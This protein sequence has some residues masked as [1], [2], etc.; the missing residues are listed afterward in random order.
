[1]MLT[2]KDLLALGMDGVVQLLNDLQLGGVGEV[3]QVWSALRL[4]SH[5]AIAAAMQAGFKGS[6]S[7]DTSVRCLPRHGSI[8][9]AAGAVQ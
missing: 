3:L 9:D 1:M 5:V 4:P 7:S 6:R 8:A 2:R